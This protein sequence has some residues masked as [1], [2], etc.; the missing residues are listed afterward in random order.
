[1]NTHATDTFDVEQLVPG[2]RIPRQP[3]AAQDDAAVLAAAAIRTR[4][5][6]SPLPGPLT[7]G[8]DRHRRETCRMFLDTF[9]PYRPCWTGRSWRRRTARIVA[10]PILLR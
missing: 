8:S 10:L 5:W 3:A 4:Q 6:R 7:P 2:F 1:M 9:N